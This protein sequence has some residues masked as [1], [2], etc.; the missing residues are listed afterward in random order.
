MSDL[1]YDTPLLFLP[2]DINTS[3]ETGQWHLSIALAAQEIGH[4][5]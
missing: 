4:P 3:A 5:W 1:K 2:N